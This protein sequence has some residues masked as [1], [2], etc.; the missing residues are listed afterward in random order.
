MAERDLPD[1]VNVINLYA[2]A[3]DTHAWELFDQVFTPDIEIG[4]GGPA[5]WNSLNAL[6][7]AFQAIHEPFRSTQHFTSNHQVR[8]DGDSATATSY[9]RAIF[10]RTVPEGGDTFESTGWYDDVLVRT[11]MGWRIKRRN[12]R[13]TWWGGN[14][15]VLETAPGAGAPAV[16]DSLCAEAGRRTIFHL[17]Q[18]R[19]R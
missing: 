11:P 8:V 9:V 5:A 4:F 18:L 16:L 15:K 2:L 19:K 14:P 7:A 3:V 17:G 6:L 10:Q 12:S 1:I 13:M